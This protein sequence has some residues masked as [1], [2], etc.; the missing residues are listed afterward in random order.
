MNISQ[1]F[2]VEA[3]QPKKD[4]FFENKKYSFS[5]EDNTK[6]VLE[7][8]EHLLNPDEVFFIE[9]FYV[10]KKILDDLVEKNYKYELY[11]DKSPNVFRIEITL[12][13]TLKIEELL[14]DFK[15]MFEVND[16]PF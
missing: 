16:D 3:K 9:L 12:K 6:I 4:I 14:E 5:I 7:K 15:K 1:S 2:D 10:L 13:G 11:F 8:N